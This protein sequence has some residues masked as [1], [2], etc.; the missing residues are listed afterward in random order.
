MAKYILIGLGA[1]GRSFLRL[2][3]ETNSISLNDLYCIDGDDNAKE[4]FVFANGRPDNFI[5][6]NVTKNNY[7]NLLENLV[8]DDFV[9]DFGMNIK[10]IDVLKY[11]IQKGAH[12]LSLSDSNWDVEDPEW[13]SLHQH[14]LEYVNIKKKTSRRSA[15]S[16]I[17]FGMNPG[18]VSCMVKRCMEE[19]VENDCGE[20]VSKNRFRLR[21]LVEKGKFN[22]LSRKLG[23]EYVVEVD[24][25][26]QQFNV[27]VNTDKTIMSTWAPSA[28]LYESIA[29]PEIMFG[30]K[31]LFYRYKEVRD[32]D[33]KD[34]YHSLRKSGIDCTERVFSPQG[35][36][37]GSLLPHEEVFTICNSLKHHRYKPT[38]FF[39]YSA[40]DEAVNSVIKCRGKEN[41]YFHLL[42]RQEYVSGGESVG[43]ILQGKRFHARYYGNYIESDVLSETATILQVS[44]S[45]F[46]AFQYMRSNPQM[47]V[48]FPDEL[49]YKTVLKAVMPYLGDFLSVECPEVCPNL[50]IKG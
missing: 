47:G 26:D 28:F 37:K 43:I 50:G 27:Q 34:Y 44:A 48:L 39:V 10:N 6:Q 38:V 29:P 22:V 23:V 41:L 11:C 8:A 42:T 32:C 35:M 24:N 1:V 45:A 17:G 20:Y 7:R 49:D 3:I 15:T 2:I 30:S 31:R 25:D 36:V 4:C 5:R 46:A 19:I 33:F 13:I 18:L 9:F 14:Y 21:K 40:C 16:I 12:Y